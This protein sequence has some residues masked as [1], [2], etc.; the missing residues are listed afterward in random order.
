MN[1]KLGQ[2]ALAVTLFIIGASLLMPSV[3]INL[4]PLM[5]LAAGL[6]LCFTFG[7]RRKTWALVAGT[8]LMWYA[9]NRSWDIAAGFFAIRVS[10]WMSSL[11]VFTACMLLAMAWLKGREALIL[12]A[13]LLAWFGVYAFTLEARL[14]L[15]GFESLFVAV[16]LGF[17][18]A[19]LLARGRIGKWA[20]YAGAGFVAAGGSMIF[21][22]MMLGWGRFAAAAAL[23]ALSVLIVVKALSGGRKPRQ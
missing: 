9:L 13:S 7:A 18:T 20:L 19:Y 1:S 22:S 4:S 21:N 10:F 6:A 3:G 8:Y 15:P 11:F 12:P 17:A 5:F 16:G 14:P 2:I 23:I